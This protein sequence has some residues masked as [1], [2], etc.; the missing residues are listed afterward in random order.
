LT[1]NDYWDSHYK[2]R[3]F[4]HWELNYPSPELATLVA[5]RTWK[6]TAK[7]LDIGCG[8]GLDAIFLAQCGFS[9]I[10]VDIS[11]VALRIAETRAEEAN[12]IIDWRL[13]NV[14]D[15]P[16]E[17]ETIDIVTDRGLFHSI[18]DEDRPK[19]SSEV[20]RVL[21]LHGRVIIRGASKESAQDRFNPV[22][23][24]SIKKYFSSKFER[25]PVLPIPLLSIVGVMEGRIAIL[26][27]VK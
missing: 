13:G 20:Y 11:P 6:K 15:L 7:I 24:E 10:G 3:D 22:T 23:E 14:L 1:G 5:A 2:N 27:K 8:G 9:V 26:K 12:V 25:G 4:E 16:V 19:Y 17:N 21:K 18:E